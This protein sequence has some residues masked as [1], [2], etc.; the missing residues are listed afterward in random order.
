MMGEK[1]GMKSTDPQTLWAPALIA[2]IG[3][4]V[5]F[6]LW[7]MILYGLHP[8]SI[9]AP[10]YHPWIALFVGIIISILLAV[11]TGIAQIAR[12]RSLILKDMNKDLKKEITDRVSAE[13]T[14][15]KLE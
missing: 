2:I 8:F 11:T 9:T 5:S 3:I 10:A 13:E 12:H 4:L 15:Q 1:K 7:Y 14:K 6:L